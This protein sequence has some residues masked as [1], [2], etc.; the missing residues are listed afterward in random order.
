MKQ[1]Q[2]D[3]FPLLPLRGLVVYPGMIVPLFVGRQS[4]I[5]A[6]ENAIT[7]TDNKILLLAQ[8]DSQKDDPKTTDMY[9][10]GVVA[11]ILQVLKLQDT[12][13]KVLVEGGQ[14]VKVQKFLTE[15]EFFEAQVRP[16]EDDL[17][18]SQSEMEAL[19]RAIV[20]QFEIY[21]RLNRK[22]SQDVVYNISQIQDILKFSD[23]VAAHLFVK[24]DTKQEL[25]ET[26]NVQKRLEKLLAAL[27]M[28]VELLNT[29]TKI[30]SR[31]RNQLEKQH[32]D[33]ILNEQ[34]KA[35]HKELGEEDIKDE[36]V[37][38]TNKIKK[39][40]LAPSSKT[41]LE[42]DIKKLK[43]MNP[44][45]SEA[46][47]I[48]NYL[49][50]VVELPWGKN[51]PINKDISKAEKV[52]E[53]EHYGLEKVK[54]RILEQ[55][56]VNLRTDNLK[57][58]V[59]C[60][61]GPPGVGKTSLARSIANASGRSFA[62]VSLGGLRDEAEIKGHR[63][64]YIGAMPGKIINA[65]KKAKVSNP[66]MLLDEIDKMG[67]DYRGDPA[68]TMLEM[69]D[70]EQNRNF[71]DHYLEIDYD[72]SKVMFVATANN[73]AGIPEPLLDRMEVI[74]LSGY[75]E[76]EKLHIARDYLI[77][78]QFKDHGVKAEELS[79]SDEALR[80]IIRH[81]TREAGVRN[82][83]RAI[84]KIVR[85]VVR[86]LLANKEKQKYAISKSNLNKFLGAPRYIL[87]E[88]EERDLV[89]ITN[90]LAYTDFGGDILAIEVITSKGKGEI[91]I[92]GKLGDVMKESVQA[93]ASLVRSRCADLGIPFNRIDTSNI[94]LHVPEG[95]TPK[96]GPSAGIAICTSLVSAL[97]DIPVKHN[98]AMTGEI[99]LRGR[100]L[101]IGG[102]KEKLLAAYRAGIKTVLIPKQNI[103]DL[104]E[105]PA[106]VTQGLQII[107]VDSIDEVLKIALASDIRPIAWD[108][109][110][111]PASYASNALKNE[112]K[113]H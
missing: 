94:H 97:T 84:A 58:P 1:S 33:Y 53:K 95:A 2:N 5:R 57:S 66:L 52:L 56:A 49:D 87:G 81:Y 73:L 65:I 44:M 35:I 113:P 9:K 109:S 8:R 17:S 88:I 41:K 85:K 38:L 14:R 104:E 43:M 91:Q 62:K 10:I 76:D 112:I 51:S 55:I 61:V 83:E 96:D 21:A 15:N 42:S 64:T 92:T 102:L 74:R 110:H 93:A 23:A 67:H 34:L 105:I 39:L 100:V 106:K 3:R 25:L 20:N 40:K 36:I 6:L 82:L 45:S 111:L 4:S 12:T 69:L 11:T 63:R 59:L 29:Q 90:G 77:P 71:N 27:D 7:V 98:V 101:A 70:P 47:V 32:K 60:L 30:H 31:V 86:M 22:I 46:A 107:P 26:D 80:E 37:E 28:E 18:G 48:R 99:T 68:S 54:E 79:L 75:T 78:R 89:G 24:V 16:L 19:V 108:E 72:L 50:T 103:K 13:V